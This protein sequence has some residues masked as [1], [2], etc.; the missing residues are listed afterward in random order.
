MLE[1]QTTRPQ[2]WRASCSTQCVTNMRPCFFSWFSSHLFSYCCSYL[3]FWS[4]WS[5]HVS[6]PSL[7]RSCYFLSILFFSLSPVSLSFWLSMNPNQ[8][9]LAFPPPE[10]TAIF[11]LALRGHWLGTLSF[12]F[13]WSDF[14]A[15]INLPTTHGMREIK[16]ADQYV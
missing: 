12:I 16:L 15:N 6:V 5:C 10:L 1:E 2:A 9:V 11:K 4:A 7:M 14:L 13:S 8:K 3:L